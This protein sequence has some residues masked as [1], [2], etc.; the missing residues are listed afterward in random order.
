MLP[1]RV[2]SHYRILEPVGE[3]AVG[4]V[5]KALDS[6]LDRLVALKVISSVEHPRDQKRNFLHEARAASALTH[7]N[8]VRVYDV[9]SAGDVDYIAMEFVGGSRLDLLIGGRPQPIPAAIDYA[10]QIAA[11]LRAAHEAGIV[12]RDLKPNNIIVDETGC[13][14]LLDF[15]LAKITKAQAQVPP[16]GSTQTVH[17]EPGTMFGTIAYMPPEQARGDE[18][19]AR[20]DIFSL[21]VILYEMLTGQLPFRGASAAL[22]FD[23]ILNRDPTP[24]RSLRPDI[25]YALQAAVLKCL[26]KQKSERY[27]SAAELANSLQRIRD[28]FMAGKPDSKPPI[29][30]RFTRRAGIL[31]ALVAAT[32]AAISTG[33]F[34][35]RSAVFR[36]Q[37]S[38]PLPFTS[39]PG[40]EYEPSFSPNGKMLA[41][42]WNGEKQ[43]NFD[44][45]IQ[46]LDG[47]PPVRLTTDVA[48]EGSPSW[49]PDSRRI[50]FFRYSAPPTES[51]FYIVST[52]G[53]PAA[54]ITSALPLPQ[55]FDRHLDWS[56]N[57]KE[58]AIVDKGSPEEPFRIY[59][60]PEQAGQRRRFTNPP[61][62]S[63]GDTGPAFSPDGRQLAFRRTTSAV[64]NEL[65]VADITGGEPRRLT[66]DNSFT[67]GH[68]WTAD[69]RDIVFAS[70]RAGLK[71]VWRV[72]AAGGTPVRVQEAGADAYNIA[73]SR[74]GDRLAYSQYIADTNIWR[75]NL[76][77]GAT[78]QL[79]ASTRNDTSPQLS[80]TATR[81]A[82]RSNRSGNDEI[83]VSTADGK[84]VQQ[85]THFDGSMTGTPRWSPDGELVAFDSRPGGN[86]DIY[87]V[88]ASGG[89]P[90]RLTSAVAEDVVPSWSRDGRWIYFSSNRS[91]EWQIWKIAAD[92]E[93]ESEAAVQITRHG[94][95]NAFESK[96]GSLIYYAKGRNL[97]GIWK[98]PVAGGEESIEVPQLRAGHW[99]NW[100]L[101]D[102]AI[103]F[104]LPLQPDGA[105]VE[106][107]NLATRTLRRLAIINKDLPFSDSGF[108]ASHDGNVIVYSQVDQ[109]GSDILLLEGFR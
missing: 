107:H 22:V 16:P 2:I 103:L 7:P 17:T 3:G 27:S 50:A 23:G 92:A 63:V 31:V 72:S 18:A 6:R 55:I 95:F 46:A 75:K 26:A 42:A 79:V 73:V 13:V 74:Q 60:V 84:S 1:V 39:L 94:G 98:V 105:S 56:P 32:V 108:A 51:G 45:Y 44:I 88:R 25:P 38:L 96:E 87:V 43:D 80:P 4:T 36:L 93:A 68:A 34:L 28:D 29:A 54:K 67:S 9:G 91:G 99:G 40:G 83:W 41:F 11:G 90:R 14:K 69:G 15:G 71:A 100:A 48:G 21:G 52:E 82:F 35:R 47:G 86:A 70:A 58:L 33:V 97:P 76:N 20:A 61:P 104:T 37:P 59:L 64:V 102:D 19:D 30:G 53:G 24:P 81:L 89:S 57:G 101:T 109:A 65:Y 10:L 62:N 5:Y 12:H 78:Q 85:L 106:L 77:T 8:I 49:S 66:F